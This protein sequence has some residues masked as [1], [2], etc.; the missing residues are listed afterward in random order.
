MSQ[1]ESPTVPN[2]DVA[3]IRVTVQSLRDLQLSIDAPRA[4]LEAF[5][6]ITSWLRSLATTRRSTGSIPSEIDQAIRILLRLRYTCR[7][8]DIRSVADNFLAAQRNSGIAV[9]ARYINTEVSRF[10]KNP[11]LVTVPAVDWS[12]FDS[13]SAAR[14]THIEWAISTV[15]RFYVNYAR[16]MD[17][18]MFQEGGLQLHWRHFIAMM[19]AS[20]HNCEYLVRNQM[21]LFLASGGDVAW[22]TD[23]TTIP[24]QLRALHDVNL[25]L[26]HKP[27]EL[28]Q[29][30]MEDLLRVW[31]KADLVVAL[32]ILSTF[33]T[34][35]VVAF[36]LGLEVEPDLRLEPGEVFFDDP[37]YDPDNE[38]MPRRTCRA[39]LSCFLDNTGSVP[40]TA[41]KLIEHAARDSDDES[42]SQPSVEYLTKDPITR[43]DSHPSFGKLAD[44]YWMFGSSPKTR[45]TETSRPASSSSQ[46]KTRHTG[47]KQPQNADPSPQASSSA[48]RLS[49]GKKSNLSSV[50]NAYPRVRAP[51][52]RRFRHPFHSSE[53]SI[54]E[55]EECGHCGKPLHYLDFDV[56]GSRG[57]PW[58]SQFSWDEQARVL[59]NHL[60]LDGSLTDAIDR[61]YTEALES[62]TDHIGSR[63]V[64]STLPLR[65]AILV[66]V[67]QM[68][69][70]AHH[71]YDY[72]QQNKFLTLLQKVVLKKLVCYP[73]RFS[74]ADFGRFMDVEQ[75]EFWEMADYVYLIF[76]ARRVVELTYALRALNNAMSALDSQLCQ[77]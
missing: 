25:I 67:H 74:K 30:H 2:T 64:P 21:E 19:A 12:L 8:A 55:R 36:G 13:S 38:R 61:E 54:G 32:A 28:K 27:W 23:P 65:Q 41:Q 44:H 75:L 40:F 14:I 18:L 35:P 73:E 77:R 46:A 1:D 66:Y 4:R 72:T 6:E 43:E 20:R 15:P 47:G 26:C 52:C 69:G 59:M 33:H 53:D 51:S 60:L 48:I 71:D 57:I 34:L 42:D 24:K 62:A 31:S 45:E 68:Y 5:Q 22:L 56:R 63:S 58:D 76:Q 37:P 17:I 16:T 11:H 39:I 49:E 29:R 10:S 3:V 7:F 9:A 70:I 50:M